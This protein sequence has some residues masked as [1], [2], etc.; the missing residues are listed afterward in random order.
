MVVEP[1]EEILPFRAPVANRRRT[2]VT[3]TDR[4]CLER[5]LAPTDHEL[6]VIIPAYN[7][8]DRLPNSLAN[9]SRF[10]DFSRIDYRV[11]VADDGSR[12]DTAAVTDD[13]VRLP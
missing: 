4:D 3:F 2:A 13:L 10:L 6:T 8:Q 5:S 11:L 9:L 12:D 7:E 1:H